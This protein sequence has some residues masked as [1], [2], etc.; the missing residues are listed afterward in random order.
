MQFEMSGV[1][2]YKPAL[3][4]LQRRGANGVQIQVP[5]LPQITAGTTDY[6][7]T[8]VLN[9]RAPRDVGETT[10]P[11]PMLCDGMVDSDGKKITITNS[12]I[13]TTGT[14]K[15]TGVCPEIGPLPEDKL[16]LRW[17]LFVNIQLSEFLHFLTTVSWA[18]SRDADRYQLNGVCLEIEPTSLTAAASN[19]RCLAV[20]ESLIS[21]P[22]NKLPDRP[23][24]IISWEALDFLKKIPGGRCDIIYERID[25]SSFDEY[26]SFRFAAHRVRIKLMTAT[27]PAYRQVIPAGPM[28]PTK[29]MD[30]SF[31]MIPKSFY[32]NAVL[33]IEGNGTQMTGTYWEGKSDF[34]RTIR[35]NI[36]ASPWK[37]RIVLD[38]HLFK[39]VFGALKKNGA[40]DEGA[41]NCYLELK[42]GISPCCFKHRSSAGATLMTVVLMPMREENNEYS[43]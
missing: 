29:I 37:G 13:F 42:D 35:A 23:N 26:L 33:V 38:A 11:I 22:A 21:P 27:Y 25:N 28:I 6:S 40:F 16:I 3:N 1:E 4:F 39:A 10:C 14:E 15:R 36:A 32:G 30:F 7:L 5:N 31:P 8:A 19:G 43:E 9:A 17:G 12:A 24:V 18:C 41:C 34:K 20:R 2:P